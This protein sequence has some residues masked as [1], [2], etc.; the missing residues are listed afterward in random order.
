MQIA[1]TSPSTPT[2][3]GT[4]LETSRTGGNVLLDEKDT[5]KN[6]TNLPPTPPAEAEISLY[7]VDDILLHRIPYPL[8]APLVGYPQSSHGTSDYAFH[9][10]KDLDRCTNGAVKVLQD[11]GLPKVI[12][13]EPSVPYLNIR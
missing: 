12:H 8:D 1:S 2:L 11:S 10:A 7:T 9:T 5:L 4:M 6:D 13:L 3:T